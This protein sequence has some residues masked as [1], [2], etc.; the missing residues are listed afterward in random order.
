[1][2]EKPDTARNRWASI[3]LDSLP[4]VTISDEGARALL[5]ATA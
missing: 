2:K 4:P 3:L 1:L 5:A